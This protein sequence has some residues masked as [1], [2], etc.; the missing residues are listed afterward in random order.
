MP[1]R[2]GP[3]PKL[4]ALLLV[5]PALGCPAEPPTGNELIAAKADLTTRQLV[6]GLNAKNATVLGTLTV[7][8]STSGSGPR[9]L[10]KSEL[11]RLMLP[12]PPYEQLGPGPPGL[13]LLRDGKQRKRAV[14]LIVV[15]PDLKVLA[16][17]VPLSQYLSVEQGQ[18]V[19]GVP[20]A[21]PEVISILAP[22][23]P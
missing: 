23:P 20:G 8:T 22:A 4:W 15:G 5:I 21:D 10:T 16:Q 6:A 18:A 12:D 7:L 11:D 13:M 19:A 2:E 9:P 14:R 1:P 3:A 17:K